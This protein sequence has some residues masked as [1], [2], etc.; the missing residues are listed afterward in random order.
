[1]P[2]RRKESITPRN[3]VSLPVA[4]PLPT[5]PSISPLHH[6][7]RHAG[8]LGK[9]ILGNQQ[10]ALLGNPRRVAQ[11]RANH[12]QG[13]LT[14]QFRFALLTGVF[15]LVLLLVLVLGPTA[16]IT[17]TSTISLSTRTTEPTQCSIGCRSILWS[18]D[19]VFALVTEDLEGFVE[20]LS[21][22]GKDRAA[23]NATAF[24]MLDLWLWNTHSVHFPIDVVCAKSNS[25]IKAWD[26]SRIPQIVRSAWKV[27]LTWRH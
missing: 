11:P 23:T 5:P 6:H 4:G 3:R 18:R 1:M 7:L 22:V 17:S 9:I 8:C 26:G 10:I 15:V 14:L 2:L 24:V 27:F 19:H 20:E 25:Q 21:T 16:S 13:E 12:V